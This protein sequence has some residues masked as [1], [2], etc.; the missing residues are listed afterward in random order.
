MMSDDDKVICPNCVHEFTAVPVTT[1]TKLARLEDD[2]D[3]IRKLVVQM[4]SVD[5][6]CGAGFYQEA[7]WIEA[8]VSLRRMVGMGERIALTPAPA[9]C[10]CGTTTGVTKDGWYG[11]RC[12]SAECM[13]F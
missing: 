11:Y 5:D 7:E 9:C 4:H 8:Y 13:V 6:S 1:Q 10:V 3:R 12:G 2:H